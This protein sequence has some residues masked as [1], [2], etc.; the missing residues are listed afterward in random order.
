MTIR[1]MVVGFDGSETSHRAF[2]MAIGLA[3]R[4]RGAVYACYVTHLPAST[5]LSGLVSPA[6]LLEDRKGNDELGTFVTSELARRG[7]AGDFI[8]CCGDVAS[9]LERLAE[10]C[11]ADLLVVGRTTHRHLYLAGISRDLLAWGRRPVLVVP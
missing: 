1:S 2:A 9:E 8:R 5:A 11:G 6:E 7:I 4:E 10:R 3:E